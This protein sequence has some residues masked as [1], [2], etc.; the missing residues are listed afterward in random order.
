[1]KPLVK[2]AAFLGILATPSLADIVP[3]LGHEIYILGEVHDNPI[4]H[5][6]QSRLVALIDPQSVVWE[7]LSDVQARLLTDFD[8]S[9]DKKLSLL[10]DWENSGWPDFSM[11]FPI[12]QASRHARHLAG[13]VPRDPLKRAMTAGAATVL[14]E[15]FPAVNAAQA[16]PPFSSEQQRSLE[17]EQAEAHCNALPDEMLGGMVEAQR[18]R[19]AWMAMRA[20]EA[21]DLGLSPVVIITGTGHARTDVA[22]AAIIRNT[23]PDMTIWSLGQFESDPGPDA[24]FDAI[25]VTTAATRDDPCLAFQK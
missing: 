19:D 9:D 2:L 13:A 21:V 18:L 16:L 11:Y 8:A 14:A 5:L 17:A 6:E 25:N 20:L 7:M 3:P 1:M 15:V 23:R 10:L 22:I 4:H 12:F 24:P